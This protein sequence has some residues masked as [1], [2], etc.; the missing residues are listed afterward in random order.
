MKNS[1]HEKN[2]TIFK[3]S[4][5]LSIILM[6]FGN[7]VVA[8]EISDLTGGG[9]FGLF[10]CFTFVGLI[11]VVNFHLLWGMIIEYIGTVNKMSIDIESIKENS[12]KREVEEKISETVEIINPNTQVDLETGIRK[13]LSGWKCMKCGTINQYCEEECKIC[14]FQR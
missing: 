12:V 6:I 8:G 5:V 11:V 13:P 7:G 14:G 1:W 9:G 2:E 4:F 3:I 10:C